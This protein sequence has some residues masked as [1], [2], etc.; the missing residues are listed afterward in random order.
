MSP[1]ERPLQPAS[2]ARVH[3]LQS[4]SGP[5]VLLVAGLRLLVVGLGAEEAVR[6]RRH[7]ASPATDRFGLEAPTLRLGAWSSPEADSDYHR[8][9]KTAR[10]ERQKLR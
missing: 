10:P 4:L 5:C 6:Q 7:E 9:M 8:P 3:L 2:E 1:T